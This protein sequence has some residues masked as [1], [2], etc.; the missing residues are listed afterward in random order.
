MGYFAQVVNNGD[1]EYEF[2]VESD[3]IP[4]KGDCI[5]NRQATNGKRFLVKSVTHINIYDMEITFYKTI[6]ELEFIEN[7]DL[8]KAVH[9]NELMQTK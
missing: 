4:R 8:T 5:F 9:S 6:V 1:V 7:I 3:V 2:E